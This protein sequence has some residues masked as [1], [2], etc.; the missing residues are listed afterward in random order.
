MF[1]AALTALLVADAA[2]ATPAVP[3]APPRMPDEMVIDLVTRGTVELECGKQPKALGMVVRGTSFVVVPPD[4][5]GKNK[6]TLLQR[7]GEVAKVKRSFRRGNVDIFELDGPAFAFGLPARDEPIAGVQLRAAGLSEGAVALG[8]IPL[9]AASEAVEM[10]VPSILLDSDARV[11][12]LAF[13]KQKLNVPEI[14][15][16]IMSPDPQ[17]S[18]KLKGR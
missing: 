14:R 1:A 4:Y 16:A 8:P 5:V 7:S 6:C 2:V 3:P 12:G 18:E 9:P 17:K 10:T 15:A 11:G 13:G